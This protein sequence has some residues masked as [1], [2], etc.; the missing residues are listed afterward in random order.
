ME[1]FNIINNEQQQ[2]FQLHIDGELA[3]LEYR[4]HDGILV[5]MHTEVPDQLG[6]RGIASAL[7]VAAFDYARTHHLKVKVYCPFVLSYVKRHP[8][9]NDMVIKPS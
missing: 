4:F 1:S 7:V 5:L 2:Q 8:E 3:F 6:G 9:L